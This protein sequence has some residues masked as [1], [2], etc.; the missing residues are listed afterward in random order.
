MAKTAQLQIRVALETRHRYMRIKNVYGY[1]P[2]GELR[3]INEKHLR[4]LEKKLEKENPEARK[5]VY[6]SAGL[7]P[8]TGD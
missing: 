6:E 5:E 4:E 8:A 7:K 2:M 1:D 3:Y